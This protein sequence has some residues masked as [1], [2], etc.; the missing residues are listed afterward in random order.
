MLRIYEDIRIAGPSTGKGKGVEM[1]WIEHMALTHDQDLG[2]EDAE[3][4][5]ERELAL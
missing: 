5:L 4:D 1:P 3:N 2:I